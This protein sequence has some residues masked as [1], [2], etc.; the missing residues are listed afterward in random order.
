ML[1]WCS[2]TRGHRARNLELHL[3]L[4][5]TKQQNATTL[6][7]NVLLFVFRT[8]FLSF[9][10]PPSRLTDL[11]MRT[12]LCEILLYSILKWVVLHIQN[13]YSVYLQFTLTARRPTPRRSS[14]SIPPGC[15]WA[16]PCL[17]FPMWL[18]E[19]RLLPVSCRSDLV[20]SKEHILIIFIF[21]VGEYEEGK[22]PRASP[23]AKLGN[24]G[25]WPL[26][27]CIAVVV[28]GMD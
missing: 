22:I 24:F 6:L 21:A 9:A 28:Q 1:S 18:L 25:D 23:G 27:L 17:V 11:V 20:L 2:Y 10:C 4:M 7:N 5:G 19:P 12:H 15:E 13:T 8:C 16:I 14:G 3:P 26:L